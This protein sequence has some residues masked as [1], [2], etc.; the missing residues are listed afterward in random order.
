M[1]S[2]LA[3]PAGRII[4]D[5]R[6]SFPPSTHLALSPFELYR[7]PFV[8]V[9]VADGENY[10]ARPVMMVSVQATPGRTMLA[11]RYPKALSVLY[12]NIGSN[13]LQNSP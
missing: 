12:W 8:I 13:W 2:P 5:I 3:F 11:T 4:F 10:Q 6:L 7:Q 1:F 9:A